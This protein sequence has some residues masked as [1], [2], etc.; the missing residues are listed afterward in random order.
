MTETNSNWTKKYVY[1][2]IVTILKLRI[3]IHISQLTDYQQS[4][5][6]YP[7]MEYEGIWINIYVLSSEFTYIPKIA[8]TFTV[9]I[10][11]LNN[12]NIFHCSHRNPRANHSLV[13]HLQV[14]KGITINY[15]SIISKFSKLH[16][17]G[18]NI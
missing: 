9:Y 10:K 17:E 18:Q 16:M 5:L 4:I 6:C 11:L 2:S 12:I 3:E 1:Y 13:S 15:S 8:L 14:T 7:C